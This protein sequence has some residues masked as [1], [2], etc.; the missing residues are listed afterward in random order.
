MDYEG[1]Y[2]VNDWLEGRNKVPTAPPP[3]K[4]RNNIFL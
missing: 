1:I 2:T 4:F 3:V